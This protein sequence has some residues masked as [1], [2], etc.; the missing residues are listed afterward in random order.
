[1]GHDGLD[2]LF[3]VRSRDSRRAGQGR[4]Q[5][6]LADPKNPFGIDFRLAA[7]PQYLFI[8][9]TLAFCDESRSDPP[10]Q[11]MK[12]ENRFDQ[13]VSGCGKVVSTAK[14]TQLVCENCLELRGVKR[15]AMPSGNS[16]AGRKISNKPGSRESGGRDHSDSTFLTNTALPRSGGSADPVCCSPGRKWQ[17]R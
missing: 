15:S 11:R 14:M 3:E 1:M 9:R 10:H 17:A 12:P 5:I 13:H 4:F 7:L 8:A 6:E 16:N 2:A